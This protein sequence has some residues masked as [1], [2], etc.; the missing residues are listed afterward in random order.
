M[1]NPNRTEQA[2]RNQLDSL[3]RK[4]VHVGA[5]PSTTQFQGRTALRSAC[6]IEIGRI[7][8]DP[9]QPRTEFDEDALGELA[10]SL[11]DRGQLQPIRVRWD[12]AAE[13]Y[14]V[15]VGER[16]WRAARLAGLETVQAIVVEGEATPEDL[17][18]DQLVENALRQDLRPIEQARA[19]R[20]LMDARGFSQRQLAERLRIS[21]ASI[22]RAIT[23]LN[24]PET[25]QE[26]VDAGD[27]APTTA[28]ALTRIENREEQKERAREVV[29]G[30]TTGETLLE[31]TQTRTSRKAPSRTW[32]HVAPGGVKVVVTR[33][34]GASDEDVVEALKSAL[35]ARK[36]LAGKGRAA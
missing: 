32:T 35:A 22:A 15:V 1:T 31:K 30:K 12:A 9:G 18:E 33:P 13:T 24:L 8:A 3:S 19:Y 6:R 7:V 36:K 26:Q 16:R 23:L 21:Q 34:E 11:R 17:L 28:Y 2:L 29:E 14:V 10:E 4:E 27:I 20:R 5:M 25:I